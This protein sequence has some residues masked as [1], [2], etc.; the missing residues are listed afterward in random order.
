MKE[1]VFNFFYFVED[2]IIN[3]FGFVVHF[4]EGTDEEKLL[5]L[6]SQIDNDY[7]NSER[8]RVDQNGKPMS[9]EAYTSLMRLGTHCQIFESVF[10]RFDA[11]Q[12]PMSC[13]T[14][15]IDGK[16]RVDEVQDHSPL[17]LKEN[18]EDYLDTYL[19][20]QGF[21]L[22]ALINDDYFEAIKLLFNHAHYIAC[23]KLLMSFIDTIA[24][25]EYGDQ[26]GVFQTWLNRFA[27]LQRLD[28]TASQ[29]WELRNSL[30]HMSNLD[31]RKVLAGKEK[32]ISF[33]VAPRGQVSKPSAEIHYFNLLDLIDVLW[34]AVSNWIRSLTEEPDKFAVFIERYDRVVR[35]H[36]HH[37][38]LAR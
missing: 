27:D 7:P 32:R 15:I 25:L 29:L 12:N 24:F 34:E 4:V 26:Q 37:P 20:S 18:A 1:P 33:S 28:I 17:R 8:F 14:A 9:L 31:S 21:D 38:E 11:G 5:Y 23:L 30:V 36:K 2:G 13:L 10:A 3:E 16:P 19:T 22:P 35:L 6:H